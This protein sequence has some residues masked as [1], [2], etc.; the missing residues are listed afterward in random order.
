MSLSELQ[1]AGT[2]VLALFAGSADGVHV[3]PVDDLESHRVVLDL[4]W[5][6][7][8]SA[9]DVLTDLLDVDGIRVVAERRIWDRPDTLALRHDF[10]SDRPFHLYLAAGMDRGVYSAVVGARRRSSMGTLA[11]VGASWQL[12]GQLDVESD[13]RWMDLTRDVGLVR[14]DMGGGDTAALTL[15]LV[16]RGR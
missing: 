1:L 2:S 9:S 3:Q 11:Q 7:K 8:R 5:K 14:G 16:W 6:T 12:T 13:I 4:H 15:S 10:A